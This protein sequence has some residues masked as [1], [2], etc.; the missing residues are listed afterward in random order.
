M[1]IGLYMIASSVITT[2]ILNGQN[3]IKGLPDNANTIH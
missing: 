3:S 2:A 1:A